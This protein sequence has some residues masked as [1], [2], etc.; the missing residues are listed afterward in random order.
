MAGMVSYRL[1]KV[2]QVHR[3]GRAAAHGSASGSGS[4]SGSG[5]GIG[6]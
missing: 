5:A 3:P 4:G 6:R 2:D 1:V